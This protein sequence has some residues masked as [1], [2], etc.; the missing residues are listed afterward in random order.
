MLMDWS[1]WSLLFPISRH[2]PVEGPALEVRLLCP[3]LHFQNQAQNGILGRETKLNEPHRNYTRTKNLLNASCR[4]AVSS[5][6]LSRTPQADIQ[7]FLGHLSPIFRHF[8]QHTDLY[9]SSVQW[10]GAFHLQINMNI[11]IWKKRCCWLL[12]V[13]RTP[14]S[15]KTPNPK[16]HIWPCTWHQLRSALGSLISVSS[17]L[18]SSQTWDKGP[19]M[20]WPHAKS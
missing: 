7:A 5:G 15:M 13:E 14:L 9:L 17:W 18:S 6:S 8:L 1:Q 19:A 12:W 4:R 20:G 10:R 2:S 11:S 16:S 3:M